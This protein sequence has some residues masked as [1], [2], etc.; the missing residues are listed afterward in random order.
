[1]KSDTTAAVHHCYANASAKKDLTVKTIVL[2]NACGFWS[3]RTFLFHN[4]FSSSSIKG[5]AWFHFDPSPLDCSIFI[6]RQTSSSKRS[7]VSMLEDAQVHSPFILLEWCEPVLEGG[8]TLSQVMQFKGWFV[9]SINGRESC[10]NTVCSVTGVHA[11]HLWS[12]ISRQNGWGYI[13][14]GLKENQLC[15]LLY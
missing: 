4:S 2:S 12:R 8:H 1:M 3:P 9:P 10:E 7:I 13:H 6:K 11:P 5:S 15:L 14:P